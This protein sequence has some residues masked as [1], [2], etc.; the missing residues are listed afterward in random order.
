MN[1]LHKAGSALLVCATALAFSNTAAATEDLGTIQ[2]GQE[3][4]LPSFKAVVVKFE[5][6]ATTSYNVK[7]SASGNHV[8][9]Y[10]AY[11]A[12]A[13]T[14]NEKDRVAISDEFYQ[15][16]FDFKATA[17]TTYYLYT[18]FVMTECTMVINEASA[19][20]QLELVEANPELDGI[21]SVANGYDGVDLQFNYGVSV[22][23]VTLECGTINQEVD[24][25]VNN[26]VYWNGVSIPIKEFI[27]NCYADGTLQGG[28]AMKITLSGLAKE[29]GTLPYNG[30]GIFVANYTL[31]PQPGT[32]VSTN[33]IEGPI[34]SYYPK[35]AENGT[36]EFTFSTPIQGCSNVSMGYGN[37]ESEDPNEFYTEDLPWSLKEGDKNTLVVDFRGKLRDPQSMIAS[38]QKYSVLL[39]KVIGVKDEAG[40]FIYNGAIGSIGTF[41]Y[42]I[43]YQEVTDQVGAQFNPESGSN[44]DDVENIEIIISDD[45]SLKYDGVKFSYTNKFD[46]VPT[47]VVVNF[48]KV[49]DAEGF[50]TLTV[51]VPAEVRGKGDVQVTLNNLSCAC[52]KDHSAELTASYVTHVGDV[53]T[54]VVT[55]AEGFVTSLKDFTIAAAKGSIAISGTVETPIMLVKDRQVLA[56]ISAEDLK[57]VEPVTEIDAVKYATAYQYSLPEEMTEA[58]VYNLV[59]PTGFFLVNSDEQSGSMNGVSVI[60]EI[61]AAPV[62]VGDIVTDPADGSEVTELSEITI[63]LNNAESAGW[64]DSEIRDVVLM[65]DGAVVAT[66]KKDFPEAWNALLVIFDEPITEKGV[67]TLR[68]PAGCY[69]Y[70]AN[71]EYGKEGEELTF[72][73]YLGVSGINGIAADDEV[74]RVYNLQGVLVREGKGTET[75]TDLKGLYIVNGKKVIF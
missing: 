33:G 9:P 26:G 7:L 68:I 74:I 41:S 37:S 28:E 23:K 39:L 53:M 75:L 10:T 27:A 64:A 16:E 55:P 3:I 69:T 6:P 17:G 58:G 35:D 49:V 67:Y 1:I 19:A 38:G 15:T 60:Y 62:P 63:T 46:D 72:T 42:Y 45:A 29:D 12:A 30:D 36:I 70:D 11:D 21:Y 24:F 65:R 44:I 52:G 34:L 13:G 5:A 18:S 8:F 4:T 71:G 43:P 61:E 51:P 59:I 31:A 73:Y 2:V 48:D 25:R 32:L 50:A 20:K 47:D 22:D 56:Q 54:P 40:Q 14:V 66:P 57:A